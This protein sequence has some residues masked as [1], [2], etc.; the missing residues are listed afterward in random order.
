M[1]GWVIEAG[2]GT[3]TLV[4]AASFLAGALLHAGI[5]RLRR[6]TKAREF[7]YD[8]FFAPPSPGRVLPADPELP[9]LVSPHLI[10]LLARALREPLMQLRRLEGFPSALLAS[11][12][13]V[14]WQMRMLVSPARP[15]QSKL[16]SPTDILQEAAEQVPVL[17]DGRVGASWSLMSRQPVQVDPERASAAFREILTASASMCGER[18]RLAIRILPGTESAFPVVIEIEIG[19]PGAEADP[20]AFL[21]ARHL[22]QSQGGRVEVDGRVT[23]V[24]L[25]SAPPEATLPPGIHA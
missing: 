13:R 21:I 4:G 20:L 22:L 7:D 24:Q 15:M 16:V 3:L 8:A 11:L 12:E 17:Q 1:S 10:V 14:A 23:R 5:G 19:R 2:P 6:R 25:R 9:A 18:G